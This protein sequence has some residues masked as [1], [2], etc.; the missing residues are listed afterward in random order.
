MTN[1]ART[2]VRSNLISN[3]GKFTSSFC[4]FSFC[5]L[6]ILKKR[7]TA[8]TNNKFVPVCIKCEEGFIKLT[9]WNDYWK[10]VNVMQTEVD[11]LQKEYEANVSEYESQQNAYKRS[12]DEHSIKYTIYRKQIDEQAEYRSRLLAEIKAKKNK[13]D[14]LNTTEDMNQSVINDTLRK[15]TEK[16]QLMKKLKEDTESMNISNAE[17]M[18]IEASTRDQIK[19][20][21]NSIYQKKNW[22]K[23]ATMPLQYQSKNSNGYRRRE[24]VSQST[25]IIKNERKFDKAG[26]SCKCIIF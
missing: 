24:V 21:L 26:E 11:K 18:E 6:C 19:N 3:Y 2:V 15:K 10:E 12:E 7:K 17:F 16:E 25:R 20:L 22:Q 1:I 5:R 13:L 9:L 4:G 14:N 8:H 23:E